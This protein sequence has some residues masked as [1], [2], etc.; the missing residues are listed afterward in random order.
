[1][2]LKYPNYHRLTSEADIRARLATRF[3]IPSEFAKAWREFLEEKAALKSWR[4]K[5]KMHDRLWLELVAPL[6]RE[7]AIATTTTRELRGKLRSGALTGQE[8]H[9]EPKLRAYEA[10]Q[11]QMLKSLRYITDMREA[12]GLTPKQTADQLELPNNGSHWVD[13]VPPSQRAP[14]LELFSQVSYKPKAKRKVPFQRRIPKVLRTIEGEQVSLFEQMRQRL[15]VRT[16]RDYAAWQADDK[17]N[18]NEKTKRMV[19]R[20]EYALDWIRNA[21]ENET[22]LPTTWHGLFEFEEVSED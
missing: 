17:I 16:E 13:W 11:A 21:K 14:V 20:L 12:Y 19:K 9:Y 10:Y 18:S 2:K 3:P 7:I 15:L 22:M 6:K 1:M 5:K 8:D 4:A